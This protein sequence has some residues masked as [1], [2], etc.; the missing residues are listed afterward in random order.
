VSMQSPMNDNVNGN[1]IAIPMVTT[2][3]ADSVEENANE[4]IANVESAVNVEE[5]GHLLADS[6]YT[7]DEQHTQEIIRSFWSKEE[8]SNGH[9]D[10]HCSTLDSNRNHIV[11]VMPN[12]ATSSSALWGTGVTLSWSP[13]ESDMI[14]PTPP[15]PL[16]NLLLTETRHNVNCS[17]SPDLNILNNNPPG[18][19]PPDRGGAHDAVNDNRSSAFKGHDHTANH[20]DNEMDDDMDGFDGLDDLTTIADRIMADD[21][22]PPP[23]HS[24]L[25]DREQDGGLDL[26]DRLNLSTTPSHD[27]SQSHSLSPNRHHNPYANHYPDPLSIHSEPFKFVPGTDL[28]PKAK[29]WSQLQA[30]PSISATSNP[31]A[32]SNPTDNTTMTATTTN[33]KSLHGSPFEMSEIPSPPSPL[34][35]DPAQQYLM[36]RM[37]H[38]QPQQQRMGYGSGNGNGGNQNGASSSCYVS[39]QQ[40]ASY[41]QQQH[42]SYSQRRQQ[43]NQQYPSQFQQYS[44]YQQQRQ[45]SMKS[46]ANGSTSA[47]SRSSNSYVQQQRQQQMQYRMQMQQNSG[48][49]QFG[50]HRNGNAASNMYQM[51][52]QQQNGKSPPNGYWNNNNMNM[53]KMKGNNGSHQWLLNHLRDFN[54]NNDCSGKSSREHT[55]N[56]KVASPWR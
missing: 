46:N 32:P 12:S 10:D 36:Q 13:K 16:A 28:N 37:G 41:S 34:S 56:D 47:D 38:Q 49:H 51:Y 8:T 11:T 9:P 33:T 24:P 21:D 44:Q 53:S 3:D 6:M 40:S 43:Y 22:P 4:N 31:T 2:V 7:N 15:P 17:P 19:S 27:H 30:S 25:W 52:C 55:N 39:P 29:E 18:L 50:N 5:S 1:A 35:M 48:N 23:V 14:P 42:Q 20:D 54:G 45:Q 26:F